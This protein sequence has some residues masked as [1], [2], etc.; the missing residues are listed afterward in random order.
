METVLEAKRLNKIY[1]LGEGNRN[2]ILKDIDISINKGEFVAV[3]G[4]S[5]SGKST[6]LYNVSGMDELTSGS[7]MLEQEDLCRLC[8]QALARLRLNHMGFVFQQNHL[9]KTLC[10]LDNIML[11]SVLAKKG[12][13]KQIRERALRLME[14]TGISHLAYRDISMASGGE[15]QRVSICRALMNEP[16]ILFADEPTGALNARSSE[17][18]MDLLARI[19]RQGTTILLVTHDAKVAAKTQRVLWMRDGR[20]ES[21]KMLGQVETEGGDVRAREIALTAWLSEMGF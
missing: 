7:V 8:Q 3:M 19:N 14:E 17:E 11:P 2:H 18:I 1:E 21:E 12:S 20:I 6:F 15:L 9:L 4:A 16:E 10:I 13:R 5:G